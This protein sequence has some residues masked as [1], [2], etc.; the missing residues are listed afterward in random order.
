MGGNMKTVAR[1]FWTLLIIISLLGITNFFE[2][3]EKEN[4]SVIKDCSLNENN[5]DPAVRGELSPDND[6]VGLWHFNENSGNNASDSSG[7]GNHGTLQNMN[8]SDW[9]KA[10]YGNGLEFD[11]INDYVNYQPLKE[12]AFCA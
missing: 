12:L 5:R 4:S 8:N 1:R 11:G 10:V 3:T 2:F 7:N 6:T 9:V